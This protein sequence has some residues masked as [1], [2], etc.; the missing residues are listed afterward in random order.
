MPHL[1]IPIFIAHEGCPHRC[2]FCDQH[3]ITGNPAAESRKIGLE[4]VKETI[5]KWL[6]Y[7]QRE[8][9]ATVQVAFY[10]GSFTGLPIQRQKELLGAARPYLDDVRVD[11]IRISTRPDYIDENIVSLLQQYSVSVVELGIQSL[12]PHVL[13]TSTR[14]HTDKQSESAVHL[15]RESGFTVGLQVMCGLPGDSTCRLMATA[16]KAAELGPD[17]VRIYPTLVIKGSGLEKMYLEGNYRPLSLLKALALASRMKEVFDRHHI[18]VVR[19]GLQTSLELEKKIV[20]GPYH[21]AFG[22]LV[23]TRDLFSRARK[24]LHRHRQKAPKILSV[25]A[26]DESAFRGKNNASL[27]R[28]AALGLLEGIEVVF[29]KEQD[30]NTIKLY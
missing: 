22:E 6:A 23:L 1:I 11:S 16:K 12:D 7:S 4:T 2:I 13:E 29:D 8:Q 10:G 17:F 19:M 21:P 9:K 3:T 30:R 25:A 5:E 26:A 18:R 27:K 24:L 20:A 14:G 15:L 28:L